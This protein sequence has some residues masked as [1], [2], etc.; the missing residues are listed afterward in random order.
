M[1]GRTG[2]SRHQP[3]DSG[4]FPRSE[5]NQADSCKLEVFGCRLLLRH[6]LELYSYD[7]QGTERPVDG[8][9]SRSGLT[10]KQTMVYRETTL[11]T[12]QLTQIQSYF[13]PLTCS[14]AV[15]LTLS[16]FVAETR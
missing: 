8:A 10:K 1:F 11:S 14:A 4:A 3:C 5:I 2:A 13:S 6:V 7:L 9:A 16:G 15:G 12:P